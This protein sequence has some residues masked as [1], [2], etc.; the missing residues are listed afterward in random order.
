MFEGGVV[1]EDMTG[2]RFVEGAIVAAETM[3][4]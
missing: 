1:V 2:V 3:V 4:A